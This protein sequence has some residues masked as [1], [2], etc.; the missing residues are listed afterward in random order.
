M[1]AVPVGA[2]V[3]LANRQTEKTKV[4]VNFRKFREGASEYDCPEQQQAFN[5]W[6]H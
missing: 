1:S 4:T 2:K 3:I 5:L 6:R